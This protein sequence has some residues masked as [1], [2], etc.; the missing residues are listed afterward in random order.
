MDGMGSTR[1]HPLLLD[2]EFAAGAERA[3]CQ[4]RQCRDQLPGR[5]G[6][7]AVSE[8]EV[9]D[10]AG[11]ETSAA[12]CTINLGQEQWLMNIV[13]GRSCCVGSAAE[14]IFAPRAPT[15]RRRS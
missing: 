9:E 13:P 14:P 4:A 11:C 10:A 1:R 6:E 12:L 8:G 7:G 3:G 5:A 15:R 2:G